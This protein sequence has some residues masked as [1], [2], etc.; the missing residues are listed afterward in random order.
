MLTQHPHSGVW[1][2]HWDIVHSQFFVRSINTLLLRHKVEQFV[3]PKLFLYC[4]ALS[5]NTLSK[6]CLTLHYKRSPS[7]RQFK[8]LPFSA[9]QHSVAAG[10]WDAVQDF[11]STKINIKATGVRRMKENLWIWYWD[12]HQSSHS[13]QIFCQT[14]HVY[15]VCAGV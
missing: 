4:A 6:P 11:L 2:L 7:Y 13:A 1:C 14:T 10:S 8:R 9:L 15:C 3:S 5:N 12:Q